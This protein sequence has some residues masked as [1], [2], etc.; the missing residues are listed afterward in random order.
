MAG[1][2]RMKMP[3][4]LAGL[5]GV[6][7]LLPELDRWKPWLFALSLLASAIL[8]VG[9][10]MLT[11]VLVG[12][13][14]AAIG[15]GL[16]SGAGRVMLGLLAAVAGLVVLARLMSPLQA[17]LATTLG[18]ELDRSLQERA[19]AAVGRPGGIAHL[20]DPDVLDRLRIVRGLG[21]DTN[22]PSL[23]ISALARVL[24]AWLQALGS[25]AVLL[26][27]HWWLGLAW[28]VMW[29]FVVFYMQREYLRV[30]QVGYGQSS[31]LRRAEYLRDLA[32]TAPAA[33][34]IR[35]WGM[36]DWLIGQFD[37][38]WRTAIEPVWQVRRPSGRVLFGSSGA[39]AA[40]NL[41]SYGLLAWAAAR[42]DL[43]LAALA[44][45][46]QALAGAN[47]Y[48]AFDDANAQLSFAAVSVPKILDLEAELQA[49]ERPRSV[50][51]PAGAPA[52]GIRFENVWFAYPGNERHAL[53]GLHLEVSAGRSLAIVGENGAGKTS[54]VKL[55]CGLYT[56]TAGHITVDGVDVADLDPAAWR[57]RV[58][59]LFQDFARYQ[60]PVRDNIAFGAPHL[61][62]DLERLRSAARQAG[63]LELIESLP[64][65]WETILSREYTGG[66]DLSG[67]QWQRIAL[68]RALFA[69]QAGARVLILDEPT[70][71]LDV[72]AEA[73]L[74]DRFL[75]LTAG[76]TTILISHRFS[77]VRRADRIV[78]LEGGAV[79]EDG[80][81][82]E[83]MALG[84]RYAEMF[85]LQAARFAE[86]G[87][88]TEP[89]ACPEP[90]DGRGAHA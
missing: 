42:G 15:A 70:A 8:P 65:G 25:A 27:F 66:V 20:E 75:E 22:R 69:V 18:R 49:D 77:T 12:Q 24:P 58:A 1:M 28:L 17:A 79:V 86:K 29:P 21:M 44:V 90:A 33:K 48:T 23:A 47:A 73:E 61:A 36:L 83:L 39:V 74:Y 34:E 85:T 60:L 19:M 52:A 67:G 32:I 55:L 87:E 4:A 68:A 76:L 40:I 62:G 46:T 41:V 63:V 78:V 64:Q 59:V 13:I 57:S 7:R 38:A 88:S 16:G 89:D 71:A 50:T 81:H 35:L 31:A 56:P 37:T 84:G 11:G 14:P 2:K 54:L 72:R 51:L 30:G 10:A 53:R 43:G 5:L 9:S 80:T 26:W 45:F 82:A 3:P 6:F